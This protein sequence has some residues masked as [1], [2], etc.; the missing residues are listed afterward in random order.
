MEKKGKSVSRSK[1]HRR[2][3]KNKRDFQNFKM[4]YVNIR[5]IKSKIDSLI[6]IANETQPQVMCVTETLL[7]EKETIEIPEYKIFYNSKKAGQAGIIIAIKENLK[8]VTVET[9]RVNEE[10]QS[11]WI[12]IDNGKN[13]INVGCVY[14]P[15]ESKTKLKEYTQMYNSIEARIKKIKVDR[16]R[17]L[18]TGDFNGKIG[19]AIEGNKEEVTKS[20]KL[21]LKLA[22]EQEL[23]YTKYK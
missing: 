22:L 3:R 15:Q 19:E 23:L 7:G 9:D 20:G 17:L 6:R 14:A 12:K 18:L 4:Y 11:L 5:G 16:E 13:K 10:H 21:L 2:S 1:V 8:H